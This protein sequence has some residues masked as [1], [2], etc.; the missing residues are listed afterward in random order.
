MRLELQNRTVR[1]PQI[2]TNGTSCNDLIN[3]GYSIGT[4]NI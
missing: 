3:K 2:G 1:T 4:S